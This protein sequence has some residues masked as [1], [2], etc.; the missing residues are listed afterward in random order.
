MVKNE[1]KL[2]NSSSKKKATKSST[3]KKSHAKHTAKK[4]HPKK[5]SHKTTHTKEHKQEK[6][7]E[8]KNQ[9]NHESKESYTKKQKRKD[10]ITIIVLGILIVL[11]IVGSFLIPQNNPIDS[12][13]S[14]QNNPVLD[15]NQRQDINTESDSNLT[16][17][18]FQKEQMELQK[19][20]ITRIK[21]QQ[22]QK[23]NQ[24]TSQ[25]NLDEQKI[26][27]CYNKND[28]LNLQNAQSQ[29]LP[30]VLGKIEKDIKLATELGI[31]GTPGVVVNGFVNIGYVDYNTLTNQLKN[32]KEYTFNYDSN[33]FENDFNKAP[34]V[35]IIYAEGTKENAEKLVSNLKDTQQITQKAKDILSDV[36]T[37][38]NKNYLTVTEAKDFIEEYDVKKTPHVYIDGNT[39]KIPSLNDKNN[40]QYT[41]LMFEKENGVY[42]FSK[43]INQLVSMIVSKNNLS[44]L[45][46]VL[47]KDM[48]SNQNDL[49]I[50]EKNAEN[51][52]YV[53]T[54][55]DCPYCQKFEQEVQEKF[56]DE[57]VDTNKASLVIKDF[58]VHKS[59]G[60]YPAVYSRCVS[61]SDYLD[62]HKELFKNK[63]TLGSSG[64]VG[65]ITKDLKEDMNQ[66]QE[67]YSEVIAKAK[68]AQSRQLQQQ[69]QQQAQ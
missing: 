12:N 28:L 4:S 41:N 6:P 44:P 59:S 25:L 64:I 24:I 57:Y 38:Y 1:N 42:S 9:K 53:F 11:V 65:E 31:N 67:K 18:D 52:V 46:Q 13:S 69:I 27:A 2:D 21:A 16:M 36:F 66:L 8:H 23:M 32:N 35:N 22:Y 30:E 10:L 37:N 60:I 17:Q 5:A 7:Q 33:N 43:E 68:Q 56:I 63:D 54:D 48:L 15:S 49:I 61:E 26:E 20:F 14:D 51:K 47:D 34:E 29:E 50:G 19:E 55:Y 45:I 39:Q 40:L 3:S 58:V 62:V